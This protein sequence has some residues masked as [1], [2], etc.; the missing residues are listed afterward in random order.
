MPIGRRQP[1]SRRAHGLRGPDESEDVGSSIAM[2][3]DM[4]E[5]SLTSEPAPPSEKLQSGDIAQAQ[6]TSQHDGDASSVANSRPRQNAPRLASLK[7]RKP[8]VLPADL[9]VSEPSK[10]KL[11]FL[12]KSALRRS[13]EVRDAA[14]RAEADRRQSRLATEATPT[15]AAGYRGG[16]QSRGGRSV[17]RGTGRSVSDR[18]AGGQA[19]GHLSGSTIGDDGARRQKVTRAGLRS[20]ASEPSR[21]AARAK[22]DINAHA[23]KEGPRNISGSG[24]T[25]NRAFIKEEAWASSDDEPD[26]AEGPRVNIEHINLIS[27]DESVKEDPQESSQHQGG[28]VR[29]DRKT[30]GLNL[31]PVRV[32]RHEHV[33]RAIGGSMDPS[34]LTSAELRRRAQQRQD[35]EGSLFIPDD[36]SETGL[37]KSAR[38]KSKVKDVEFIRDER[39]WKGVYQDEEGSREPKI[40]EEP[41]EDDSR[42]AVDHVEPITTLADSRSPVI[43][44]GT[45]TDEISTDFDRSRVTVTKDSMASKPQPS[46]RLKVKE[47]VFQSEEDRQEWERIEKGR[48]YLRQVFG[49]LK[50][51]PDRVAASSNAATEDGGTDPITDDSTNQPDPKEGHVY[52]F[53]LAPTLPRLLTPSQNETRLKTQAER[54][55]TDAAQSSSS[56]SQPSKTSTSTKPWHDPEDRL[57]DRRRT[58]PLDAATPTNPLRTPGKV[59]T[60]RLYDSGRVK[61]EWGHGGET[62]M[63]LRK[64]FLS[65]M[66]QE[67]VISNL[68]EP[69]GA[70]KVEGGEGEGEEEDE[71]EDEEEGK[72]DGEGGD[73]EGG[74]GAT[75][76]GTGAMKV[77]GGSKGKGREAEKGNG[78]GDRENK[79]KDKTNVNV[80]ENIG[81]TAWAVGEIA[82][83]FVMT[84][85]WDLLLKK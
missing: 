12:P 40:K 45:G 34:S 4:H 74:S 16:L 35:T 33:E 30:H 41:R 28:L 68:A 43:G 63:E 56:S 13:K 64:G 82:G 47:P 20:A 37:V 22:K 42:M 78:E 31:K 84:P 61:V 70:V 52:L 32:D 8:P 24:S 7:S 17:G 75:G 5:A 80:K 29:S 25:R 11:K 6:T 72:G 44:G 62:S 81:D 60:L 26:F 83:S 9:T 51:D 53:Q 38:G 50:P 1:S 18:I 23:E 65:T 46:K 14:E 39:R 49:N 57:S 71:D 69:L 54:K 48:E 15:A 76:T 85:D 3:V 59:G 77:E 27:D 2:D 67:V 73:D 58:D 21:S 55:K 66:L 19:S 36:N 10:P 79:A